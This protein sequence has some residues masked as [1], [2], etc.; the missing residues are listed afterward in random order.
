MKNEKKA[1]VRLNSAA[2]LSTAII[3]GNTL[4][5]P[6][7]TLTNAED[8]T[9]AQPSITETA[10]KTEDSK[11]LE[12]IDIPEVQ[13]EQNEI[14][15]E[16]EVQPEVIADTE[17]TPDV[18][19]GANNVVTAP[20]K[21]NKETPVTKAAEQGTVVMNF[22]NE[23]GAILESHTVSAPVGEMFNAQAPGLILGYAING[24]EPADRE[25]V[26]P[27]DDGSY[28]WRAEMAEGTT[29]IN[30]NYIV[31]EARAKINYI[32]DTTGQQVFTTDIQGVINTQPDFNN[33]DKIN[34]FI[35]K[36]YDLV[37]NG[38]PANPLE[39]NL[40]DRV[41][42][43]HLKHGIE[44]KQIESR[45]LRVVNFMKNEK[46]LKTIE[47]EHT[48]TRTDVRDKVTNE[49]TFGEWS[50]NN[51]WIF[52]E[53]KADDIYGYT[54]ESGKAPE[55]T[56]NADTQFSEV[57]INYT[58]NKETARVIVRDETTGKI[59]DTKEV[60]GDF[61]SK[62]DFDSKAE[63]KKYTDKGYELVQTD[64]PSN[65]IEFNF[66]GFTKEYVITL[67]HGLDVKTENREVS[68]T[69][70]FKFTDG[71]KVSDSVKQSVNFSRDITT[72]KVTG[73]KTI[74]DWTLKTRAATGSFDE[75]KVPTVKGFTPDKEVI[76]AVAEVT[77]D[78]KS[79]SI[80]VTFTANDEEAKVNFVDTVTGKTITSDHYSGKF[81]E[82]IE[83]TQDT[84]NDLKSKGYTVIDNPTTGSIIYDEDGTVKTI[85]VKL[86]HE[87][88]EETETH[89]VN[90]VFNLVNRET[91][92]VIRTITQTVTF[93]KVTTTDKVTGE[94]TV[95]DWK[96]D[97]KGFAEIKFPAID[98]M[99]NPDVASFPFEEVTIDSVD[100]TYDVMYDVKED[101]VDPD[102]TKPEGSKP[103]ETKPEDS[104]PNGNK[105]TD[106]TGSVD[107][108]ESTVNSIEKTPGTI[109]EDKKSEQ[110]TSEK[111]DNNDPQ[112]S[113]AASSYGLIGAIMASMSGILGA[114]GLKLRKR[115]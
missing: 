30:F 45:I 80:D 47:Q 109:V 90:R 11:T 87:V 115:K 101:V 98:G 97:Q 66:D 107:L 75:I 77:P 99:T 20:S 23:D 110:K 72:D 60:T 8:P 9:V 12:N 36:G 42:E 104:K 64:I 5:G 22:R 43:V 61:D 54:Y 16:V 35:G 32:D 76:E 106:N 59:L 57:H 68:R 6:A 103:G 65:G 74:S 81:G 55:V 37:S 112:T 102:E 26:V 1:P 14:Q 56:V 88:T 111:G 58:P 105:P 13:P 10:P 7:L 2:L 4:V 69:V 25:G 82:K 63:I 93:T 114:A 40:E 31:D 108:T 78:T 95:S 53:V 17:T 94:V 85:T 49:T 33:Q 46:P 15:P 44:E 84:L 71:D 24:A 89:K 52:P 27:L 19:T 70:N 73:E 38:V 34:E 83:F 100:Q 18:I 29:T 62:S 91:S 96:A 51:E 21:E 48:F 86:G 28:V 79:E 3:V 50:D 113:V 41:Y 92:E 39:T 67:K